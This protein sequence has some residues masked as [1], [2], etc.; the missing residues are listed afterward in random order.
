[1][2]AYW[3]K[4]NGTDRRIGN[5]ISPHFVEIHFHINL[6]VQKWLT[7]KKQ[8]H[9]VGTF[10]NV[11]SQKKTILFN[12]GFPPIFSQPVTTACALR[13]YNEILGLGA[14]CMSNFC[15]SKPPW[16]FFSKTCSKQLLTGVDWMWF[17]FFRWALGKG[18]FFCWILFLR[19][20]WVVVDPNW[21]AYPQSVGHQ[22]WRKFF[23]IQTPHQQKI[24]CPFALL[25]R[26]E[27]YKS[28]SSKTEAKMWAK[29]WKHLIVLLGD[30]FFGG[31]ETLSF[32]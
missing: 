16:C 21:L 27:A 26:A 14:V 1:M 12:K 10:E 32:F 3:S 4:Y 18:C 22:D 8:L 19:F 9:V 11:F 6:Y 23:S 15:P 30:V 13:C 24:R 5:N 7:P 29:W 28:W 25:I 2:Y 20:S 17:F 31:N